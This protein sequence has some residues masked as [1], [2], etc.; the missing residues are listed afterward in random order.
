MVQE[1]NKPYHI[2]RI[3]FVKTGSLQYVS[4]L[5][6][7]RT[8]NKVLIRTK[9]PL[10]YSEGFNPK[11]K[12]VF[13]P[14]LS[15]GVES[16]C[17]FLD[18]RLTERVDEKTAL[19]LFCRNVTEELSALDAYYPE[20]KLSDIGWY[21]YKIE[22]NAPNLTEEKCARCNEIAAGE[23]IVIEKKGKS[24]IKELDIKPLIHSFSA[25]YSDGKIKINTV[26]SADPSAILNPEL[27]IKKLD[28]EVQLFS[29]D[30]LNE[31][32]T[33]LRECAYTKDMAV[34]K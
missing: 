20:T 9:L 11:P 14:P 30:L 26:L 25:V 15:I 1:V 29:G 2:L 6:L 13:S 24:G 21:S 16:H 32:H 19:Q 33:V 27:L 12:M 5:D 7:V 23:S 10:W 28:S 31:Y 4:H 17:E 8:I 22:L 34:Y 18:V 3:K